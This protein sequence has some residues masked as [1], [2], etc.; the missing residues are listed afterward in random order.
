[1]IP[2][3]KLDK[4]SVNSLNAKMARCIKATGRGMKGVVKQTMV[5]FTQS[6]VKETGPGKSKPSKM[7]KKYRF[8]PIVKMPDSEHWYVNKATNFLFNAGRRLTG[9]AAAGLRK[10]KG[11]KYWDKKKNAFGYMPTKATSKYD[12][13]DKRTRIKHAG[14]AKAGWLG[15]Y[16]LM[17]KAS[18]NTTIGTKYSRFGFSA[19]KTTA[20]ALLTN[21]VD[22][23]RKRWPNAHR[24]ALR[25]AE[26]RMV[27]NAERHIKKVTQNV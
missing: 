23:A 18:E 7:A 16:A 10:A 20:G 15:V 19:T 4:A 25:K 8:R 27:K 5:F 13:S 24:R 1:M 6:A 21:L 22:Y 11:I 9:K 17:G 12:T 26:N 14:A 3:A 2:T